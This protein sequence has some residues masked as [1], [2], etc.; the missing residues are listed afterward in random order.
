MV[1]EVTLEKVHILRGQ[2]EIFKAL[3][4]QIPLENI[5]REY[6]GESSYKLGEA[7]EEGLLCSLIQHNN[8]IAEGK[9]CRYTKAGSGEPC[10]FCNFSYA[11]HY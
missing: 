6:G 7:P 4:E 11:R 8:E 2:D 10:R 9:P 5:P 3:L 1:D